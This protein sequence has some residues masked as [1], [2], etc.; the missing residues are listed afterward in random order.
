MF[1]KLELFK[2]DNLIQYMTITN[3]ILIV[4]SVYTL[5]NVA[6]KHE[7]NLSFLFMNVGLTLLAVFIRLQFGVIVNT[8]GSTSVFVKIHEV[9]VY[10][11]YYGHYVF[12][13]LLVISIIL[14][15]KNRGRK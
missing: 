8:P 9:N 1:D 6:K 13:L 4:L 11:N 12:Y 10:M 7:N 2:V 3:V 14:Y 15:I 5:Y